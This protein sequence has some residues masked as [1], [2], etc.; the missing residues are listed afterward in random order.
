MNSKHNDKE[1][2]RDAM[3]DSDAEAASPYADSVAGEEDPGA[4]LEQFVE[5]QRKETDKKK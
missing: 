2:K 3:K 4:A 1:N 5:E